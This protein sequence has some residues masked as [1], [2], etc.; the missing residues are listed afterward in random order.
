VKHLCWHFPCPIYHPPPAF[1]HWWEPATPFLVGILILL[2]SIATTRAVVEK[3]EKH[4]TKDWT[5]EMLRKAKIKPKRSPYT[6]V[7]DLGWVVDVAQIPAL[8]GTP[9]AGLFILDRRVILLPYT[10]VLAA[11]LIVFFGFYLMDE[12]HTYERFAPVY[13]GYRFSVITCG[14]IFLNFICAIIA[15]V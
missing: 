9:L 8:L 5:P 11:G 14:A 15:V 6:H 10:A 12:V 13:K 2:V 3:A 1:H 4:M 7:L